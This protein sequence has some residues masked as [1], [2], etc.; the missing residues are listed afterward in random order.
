M[1]S[2]SLFA[3]L[4]ILALIAS[5][6]EGLKMF[7]H[8]LARHEKARHET[9]R[10]MAQSIISGLKHNMF[11]SLHNQDDGSEFDSTFFNDLLN[12]VENDAEI[13]ESKDKG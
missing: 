11:S 5:S 3:C 13:K 2:K 6:A 4:V 9:A 8:K 10:H 12:F 1:N 7:K